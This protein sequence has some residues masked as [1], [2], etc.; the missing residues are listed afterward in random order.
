MTT[1]QL[2]PVL[3]VPLLIWRIYSRVRR[4]VGRQPYRANRLLGA[5]IFFSV[6]TALLGLAAAASHAALGALGAGLLVAFGLG[7][8]ALHLTTWENSAAGEFYT[9]NRTI[10]LAVTLLFIGRIVYRIATTVGVPVDPAS[11]PALFQSPITLLIFG[12]TAG[13]YITYYFGLYIRGRHELDAARQN[14]DVS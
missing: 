6:M 13:Y 1:S 5:A 14:A 4:N 9:P 10:G 8:L 12:V 2:V 7:A 3:L 11:R